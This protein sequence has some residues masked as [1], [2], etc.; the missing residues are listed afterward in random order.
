MGK[1]KHLKKVEELFKKSPVVSYS[2]IQRII[3]DKKETKYA[4]LLV[5]NLVRKGKIKKLTKGFYTAH[6]NVQLSIFCFKPAYFGL[7]DA[8]SF[9]NMWE[10]ETIPVILTT[11]KVRRGIR[12]ILGTN[13]LIRKI[14]KKYFFGFDYVQQGDFYIPYS[15]IEKTLIDMIYFHEKIDE[16]AIKNIAKSI[17]K[18]KLDSYLR[19]Y[20]LSIRK[21]VLNKIYKKKPI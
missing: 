2:S 15:D 11:R 21:K 4:K 20:P 5:S 8:L 3:R 6:D 19:K 10:Q 16:E 17:D 9:H 7:Q 18:K 13:V 1:E 14:E 12:E